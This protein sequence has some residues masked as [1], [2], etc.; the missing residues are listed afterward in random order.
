MM[1]VMRL[2]Q[3][4]EIVEGKSFTYEEVEDI[5]HVELAMEQLPATV[6]PEAF[7]KEF[8]VHGFMEN[9]LMC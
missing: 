6:T 4:I 2:V 9:Q 5:F 8:N 7:W 3:L 1:G